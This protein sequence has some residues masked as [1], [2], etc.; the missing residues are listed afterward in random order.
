VERSSG[1]QFALGA[2]GAGFVSARG[3]GVENAVAD[4][5]KAIAQ[6]AMESLLRKGRTP[7]MIIHNLLIE[8]GIGRF[9]E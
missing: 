2:E 4:A 5:E 6:I 3:G 9:V 7:P 1:I 8:D